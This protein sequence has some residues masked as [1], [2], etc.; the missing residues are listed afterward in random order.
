MRKILLMIFLSACTSKNINNE[1]LDIN[2]NV[3]FDE[4]KILLQEY[5]RNQGFPKID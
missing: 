5:D 3:T 1:S 2:M 4:F